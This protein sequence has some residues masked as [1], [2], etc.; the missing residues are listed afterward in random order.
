[1]KPHSSI[2]IVRIWCGIRTKPI[3]RCLDNPEGLNNRYLP[4]GHGPQVLK[5][6]NNLGLGTIV[7]SQDLSGAWV[8]GHG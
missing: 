8:T 7:P 5:L 2:W 1:M 6:D 3:L 4:I